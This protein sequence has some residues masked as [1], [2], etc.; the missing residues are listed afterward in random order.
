MP[1]VEA[2]SW[3]RRSAARRAPRRGRADVSSSFTTNTDFG[4]ERYAWVNR[5]FFIG[6]G[7][8]LPGL[9]VEHRVCRPA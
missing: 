4:D 5:T 1:Q 6:E 3:G 2:S 9:G 8:I 7:P